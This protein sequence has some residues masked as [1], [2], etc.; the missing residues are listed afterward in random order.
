MSIF[1]NEILT[2]TLELICKY[3]VSIL[4]IY[5]SYTLRYLRKMSS[6]GF[7]V[8]FSIIYKIPSKYLQYQNSVI[9]IC[10]TPQKL[11]QV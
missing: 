2:H 8:S 10:K 7:E 11:P 3:C 9:Y 1:D 5:V 6:G 4:A